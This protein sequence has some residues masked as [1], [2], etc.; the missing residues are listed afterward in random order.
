LNGEDRDTLSFELRYR[1]AE[2]KNEKM[3]TSITLPISI[4]R[5]KQSVN[6]PLLLYP[7][8]GAEFPIVL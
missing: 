3:K 7:V 1:I 2:L 8:V 4:V 5:P 6:T